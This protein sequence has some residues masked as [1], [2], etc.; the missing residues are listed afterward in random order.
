MSEIRQGLPW[1]AN[2]W[3]FKIKGNKRKIDRLNSDGLVER[4]CSTCFK[5]KVLRDEFYIRAKGH[6]GK[7]GHC[8]E[9]EKGKQRGGK[10]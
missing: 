9:C 10:L 7:S 8:M 5:W 6:K 4:Q 3:K 2:T 1:S